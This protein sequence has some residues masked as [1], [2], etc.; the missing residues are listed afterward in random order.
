MNLRENGREEVLASE[1]NQTTECTKQLLP[2]NDLLAL[3]SG[4]WRLYIIMGLMCVGTMRFKQLQRA[5]PGLSGKVLSG[6]LKELEINRIVERKVYDTYPITV[7]YSLT[8]HGRTLEPV[9]SA[10]REWGLRHR[11][12][13]IGTGD[14]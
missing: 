12:K 4:K 1:I 11:K 3:T 14:E 10:L 2:V 8:E 7:E 9:V 6:E 5:I 13:I